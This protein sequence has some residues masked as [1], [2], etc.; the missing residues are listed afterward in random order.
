M[1]TGATEWDGILAPGETLL[2]QGAPD[3]AFHMAPSSWIGVVFGAVFAGIA[4]TWIMGALTAGGSFWMFGLIHL[5]VG[6]GIV[7]VSLFGDTYK[8]R[9]T[10]YS[11]SNRN[12]YIATNFALRGRK[13]QSYPITPETPLH[14][15]PGALATI[16]FATKEVRQKRGYK[17]IPIG[18]ER[19]PD[20]ANVYG[21]MRALQSKPAEAI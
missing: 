19:I 13:L 21:M 2:W 12:A 6:L 3:R 9:H 1:N 17:T 10:F 4:F 7:V 8:R 18:F 16:H 20:G 15:S 14:Y 11:L 5:S